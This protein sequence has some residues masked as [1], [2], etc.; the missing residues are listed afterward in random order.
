MAS[1][2]TFKSCDDDELFARG[3]ARDS[4][5]QVKETWSECENSP[6]GSAERTQEFL[7]RQMNEE[8]D[9]MECAARVIA[10]FPDAPW[11]LRMQIARQVAD[12]ARHVVMFKR[13]YC[14]RGGEIGK[15]SV[16]NFQYKIITQLPTIE[17][18]LAV[19][20]RLFET[21]GVDAIEPAIAEARKSGDD[22]LARLYE[23]QLA[24]EITHVR[25]ANEY[26]GR[27]IKQSPM[28]V[29]EIGR[30]MHQAT[31]AFQLVM[32]EG[33][34]NATTY[35]VNEKGRLEAGF[36]EAEVSAA[37]VQRDKYLESMRD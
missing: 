33:A 12:E 37:K 16:L 28:K 22:D 32:G 1:E 9:G 30:A 14:A 31:E 8:I 4:R 20:N 34:M 35:S 29:F 24:D 19:Q 5:F 7:H 21:E 23:A 15:Y 13:L 36:T 2:P 26:I 11:E 3:P 18:R 27:A 6:V 25:Y 17:G 10:D